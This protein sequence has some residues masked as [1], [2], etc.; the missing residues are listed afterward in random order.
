MSGHHQLGPETRLSFGS[1]TLKLLVATLVGY[2]VLLPTQVSEAGPFAIFGILGWPIL[3]PY[4][5]AN[6][7]QTFPDILLV[8]AAIASVFGLVVAFYAMKQERRAWRLF[9]PA[10][11]V[12]AWLI[13]FLSVAQVLFNINLQ[14]A[15]F[16]LAPDCLDAG[17]IIHALAI[18]GAEYQW[19]LHAGARKGD[20]LYGWSF[21]QL[22]FY[23]IPDA[24]VSNVGS[25][26]GA[27]GQFPSCYDVKPK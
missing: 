14:R 2:A 20:A 13:A 9:W 11:S 17:S 16:K 10:L 5:F 18:S 4:A 3:A 23:R 7:L 1:A 6:A 27:I 24:A 25:P 8:P 12:I 15:A 21:R 26:R 22:D 19:H